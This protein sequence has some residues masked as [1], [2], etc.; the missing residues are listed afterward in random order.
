MDYSHLL[1][2]E[3]TTQKALSVADF[4]KNI[5][6]ELSTKQYRIQGEVTSIKKTYGTAVYFSI[7][8]PKQEAILNCMVWKNIYDQNG[9]DVE[10]GDEIIVTGNPEIYAPQGRFSLKVSTLEY[11]GEGALKKSYDQLKEKLTQEG[12]F[13][14]ERRRLPKY[15]QKIGIITSLSGVVIHD[16]TTNLERRGYELIVI[17]SRVEGKT[18]L[19]EL[20]DSLNT[21][22]KK[23]IDI[24]V[25][26]RGGGSW[27]SLQAFNTE[28][29]VRTIAE[30]PVPVLTGIGHDVD[31]TL[32][33]LVAD[34]GV[35]T[36]TAV[37][38]TLNEP[39]KI[40]ERWLQN[41]E[42]KTLM[43]LEQ[44]IISQKR[45]VESSQ[46]RILKEYT[47]VLRER[48]NSLDTRSRKITSYFNRISKQAQVFE[49]IFRRITQKTHNYLT[50]TQQKIDIARKD[51]LAYI[52]T[53]QTKSQHLLATQ[54]KTI[55]LYNPENTLKRG[56]SLL[57]KDKNLVRSHK[58][59][60]SGD[61]IIAQ[62]SDG[63]ITSTITRITQK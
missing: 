4:I 3:K 57:Y 11:A 21:F 31:V 53:V 43:R 15:P 45:I 47:S 2:E 27:E 62:T 59:V 54:Q 7:K 50:S 24:L 41:A 35:S 38:K 20:Q 30:F 60:D 63:K 23:N 19:H 17:D 37:A 26:M 5:N 55:N 9:V 32:A 29:L 33:E 18:A 58:D 14:R 1:G 6:Q 51:T 49:D 22:K 42:V 48:R 52:N 8:D 12:V 36:P 28:S 13:E 44:E 16:F 10:V 39:W 34:K 25:I 56:Y 46:E 40:L 61:T